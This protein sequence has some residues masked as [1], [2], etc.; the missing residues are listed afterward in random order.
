M[1]GS[2]SVGRIEI[3]HGEHHGILSNDA[4]QLVALL[5]REFEARRQEILMARTVRQTEFDAG[6]LPNYPSESEHIRRSAWTVAP[7]PADLE[8]RRVEITGPVD[9]KMIIN[10]LNS[11]ANVFMA[12]F[13]DSL[14]PTWQNILQGQ[15]NLRDAVRREISF[16]DATSRK[17]YRLQA[18]TATLIVRP[19]GWHLIERNVI[20]DGQPVSASIL[21]FALYLFHNSA[22]LA[23]RGSGPYFY[24]PKLEGRHEAHLWNDIFTRAQAYLGIPHGTIRATV[25]IETILAAYEM[26]EILY[27]LRDHAAGLNA[28]RWDYIFSIIKKFR[29]REDMVL[30]DRAQVTMSVPFMS[31]YTDTLV[32]ACHKRGAHAIGGMAAFIP[33]RQDPHLNERAFAKVRED[34][35]LEAGKGFDGTWVAHPGLVPVAR[36][37]FDEVLQGR[38][39]QKRE[40]REEV[41][42]FGEQLVDCGIPEAAITEEGVRN[43]VSVSLQY[44]EFWLNGNGAAAINNLMED[45]ATAEISRAQLWQWIKTNSRLV[46]GRKVTKELYVRM[47]DEELESLGGSE[48]GRYGEA[49]K[50]LDRLVLEQ[51]F[52]DFLTLPAYDHLPM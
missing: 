15:V 22:E 23:A 14:S 13:E 18:E 19:R 21:D 48:A 20:V 43:N 50:I 16:E 3:P 34:K 44:L 52:V 32:R 12:D 30:P 38:L 36:A 11:G 41:D 2:A 27:E 10:A 31:A 24:L 33:S 9:R 26:E 25:L 39:N 42:V 47:R 40:L 49:A 51:T 4:L 6:A 17:L 5:H 29:N 28:G 37:V 45:A 7:V 8:D 35:Q 46:D 1:S